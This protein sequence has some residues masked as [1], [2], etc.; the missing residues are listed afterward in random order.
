MEL[1]EVGRSR[2]PFFFFPQYNFR[3]VDEERVI[4]YL[5]AIEVV[6]GWLL[7]L[8]VVILPEYQNKGYGSKG[9]DILSRWAIRKRYK[10][11]TITN[12]LDNQ[13]IDRIAKSL[14]FTK[15]VDNTWE[16]LI[17][18]PLNA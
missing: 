11:L 8:S 1:I 14:G 2:E 10:V 6:E 16:K 5:M 4:G 17:V 7:D 9:L 15:A 18:A 13:A 12:F 3:L